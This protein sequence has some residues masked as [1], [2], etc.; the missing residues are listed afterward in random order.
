MKVRYRVAVGAA[1]LAMAVSACGGGSADKNKP[2]A[3][4]SQEAQ[5]QAADLPG[6][7]INAVAY[8]QVKQGGTIQL[9]LTAWHNQWNYHELD[10]THADVNA[11]IEPLMPTTMLVDDKGTVTNDPNFIS[12]EKMDNSSGKQVVTY[13]IN[14][15][16]VWSDGKPI[17]AQ[18]FISQWKALKGTDKKF[19]VSSSEG[20]DKIADVK[21]G[22]TEKDVIV[23]YSVNYPDYT[24]L[25][26]PLYPASTT[27]DPAVF[28]KGWADGFPVTAGPFKVDKVDQ[29]AKTLTLVP[30]DKWWGQKPK[31]DKIIFRV[32]DSS[33]TTN[34]FANG[35]LDA[36]EIPSNSADLKRAK[37]IPG[38]DVRKAAAPFQRHFT[39]NASSPMLQDVK[40][41]Q[42]VSMSINRDVIAQ[43]DLKDMD[44]PVQT[45]GN[46][47]YV[48]TQ[49]G[50]QDNTEPYAQYHP[51]KA[52]QQL[53]E[54]GWKMDGEYRKKDGKVL[55]LRCIVPNYAL[56][57][58]ECELAQAMLKEVGVKVDVQTVSD[59]DQFPKYITPGNFELAPFTWLGTPYPISSSSN[60]YKSIKAGV[61]DPGQNFARVGSADLDAKMDAAKT[62][63][64]AAKAVQLANEADK[65]IWEEVHTIMLYQRPE[66]YAAKKT[67][68]N[69]GAFG[70]K[71]K[72]W[73]SVGFTG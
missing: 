39:V 16:A 15:K 3:Q 50:Y 32:V 20:Y 5:K 72:D 56:S 44:W 57:K 10:G 48:N 31:L 45:L 62:E 25:F 61:E 58:Q 7:T 68:A 73:T 42:A 28:N 71:S 23:T 64:D 33:A 65:M 13:K 11:V 46:H 24:G 21:Q 52:K 9:A 30:N 43:S 55:T 35:E 40:V 67:L 19:K 22:A 66:I 17:S 41:R 53:D 1:I 14:E 34:A 59:D 27:G 36:V 70:F 37:E 4:S 2:N 6:A 26:A 18:D 63:L 60:I 49:K 29:T 12:E 51:D 54:A 8:D 69:Y 38:A 47:F